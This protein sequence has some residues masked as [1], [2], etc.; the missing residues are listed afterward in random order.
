MNAVNDIHELLAASHALHA[1]TPDKRLATK[2]A[3]LR[4]DSP[5][6]SPAHTND[7]LMRFFTRHPEQTNVAVVAKG[8]PMGLVN[9]HVFME[10][11]AKPY[12]KELFGRQSCVTWMNPSPLVVE[13]DTT[14]EVLMRM[15]VHQGESVLKD[16]FI[17][18]RHGH[19]SGTGSGFALMQAMSELEA[20]KTRQL[21]ASIDYAS[22]IQ[23]AHLRDSDAHLAQAFPDSSL[24]WEPRDVVGGD[25]YFVRRL[26]QGALAAVID[27]T[28]HGVPGAFMTLVVLSWLEQRVQGWPSG[29]PIDPGHW[30]SQLNRHVRRVLG[31]QVQRRP[32]E[33]GHDDGLDIAML[34]LPE[35]SD[36]LLFASAHLSLLVLEADGSVVCVDGD[37]H[38]VGYAGTPDE[39]VWTTRRIALHRPRLAMVVTDGVIDQPGGPKGIALGKQRL[40]AFFAAQRHRSASEVGPALSELLKAWQGAQC[41][42]DD[43]TALCLRLPGVRS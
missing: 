41:R 1:A 12:A 13:E 27:C 16:G 3:D 18:V 35:G 2:A 38:G 31:Q 21:L 40:A 33:L 15:A 17:T 6:V 7:E 8:R 5:S 26:P 25:G 9:K 30:L 39:T 22:H 29:E 34:W 11:Y 37:K 32:G 20:E 23:R 28:G 42:R 24:W 14:V 10:S 43:V 36:E 19:Y 4:T